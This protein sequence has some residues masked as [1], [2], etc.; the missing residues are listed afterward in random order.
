MLEDMV[1]NDDDSGQ[2]SVPEDVPWD[3][4]ERLGRIFFQRVL[5]GSTSTRIPGVNLNED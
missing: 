1:S 4:D 3:I 2:C 5:V